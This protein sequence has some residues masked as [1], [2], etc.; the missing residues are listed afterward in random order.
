MCLKDSAAG[1]VAIIRK[2]PSRMLIFD[3]V[4]CT[5][6]MPWVYK[7]TNGGVGERKRAG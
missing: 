4:A 7:P 1:T 5:I 3:P 2:T 6:R